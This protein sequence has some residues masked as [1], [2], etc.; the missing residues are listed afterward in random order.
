M[1]DDIRPTG[2]VTVPCSHPDCGPS[3]DSGPWC[4]WVDALDPRLPDGPF[5][6]PDHDGSPPR[7]EKGGSFGYGHVG[8]ES[9]AARGKAT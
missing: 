9:K 8:A 1:N 3:G 5:L 2:T 7:I 6:C 4:F